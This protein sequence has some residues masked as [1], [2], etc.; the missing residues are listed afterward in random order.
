M[1]RLELTQGKK[2]LICDCHYDLV[3][4]Y[5]WC[6]STGYAARGV[7]NTS[8]KKTDKLFMHRLL[9]NAKK[10]QIIDHVNQNKLDNRCQNLRFVTYFENNQNKS[11]RKDSRSGVKNVLW[12]ETYQK[13][14][15]Q[16]IINKRRY[17]F[18]Y[19]KD[20][21][22][23]IEVAEAARKELYGTQTSRI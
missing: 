21:K 20:L 14:L 5:K 13:W 1:K 2:T 7:W 9:T 4:D 16:F 6:F 8:T 12:Q 3:K 10:G 19:H 23:A 15:V 11:V 17:D 22:K 18:G